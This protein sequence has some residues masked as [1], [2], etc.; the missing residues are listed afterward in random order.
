MTEADRRQWYPGR[1]GAELIRRH[2]ERQEGVPAEFV[3]LDT[4]RVVR[5]GEDA[6]GEGDCDDAAG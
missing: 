5:V 3:Q 6:E 4:G 2:L 1:N